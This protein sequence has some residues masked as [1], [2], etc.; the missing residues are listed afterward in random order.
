VFRPGTRRTAATFVAV[1]AAAAFTS[2][3][4]MAPASS[5]ANNGGGNPLDGN[6]V[7]LYT[8][9]PDPGA[10]AEIAKLAKGHDVKDALLVAK[11]VLTPQAV[12]V[13]KPAP[14]DARK[15]AQDAVQSADRRGEVPV[16]VAYNIPFRD[17]AGLSAGGASNT[18]A[19]ETWIDAL[20]HG[21][22]NNKAVVLL[23]PDSLGIIPYNTDINGTVES[24]KPD[25]STTGL[26]PAQA[27]AARYTQLN[28]AVDK[29]KGGRNTA[30]YLDGTHS[31]WLGS[32]DIA[33]RM[34]KAGVQR[35]DGFFL[36][37]SNFQFSANSVQYG[38]WISDCITFASVVNPGDFIDCPNQ[39]YNGGP[40]NGFA[41]G[42]ALSPY[43][44]WSDTATEF[45]LLTLGENQ[46]YANMLGSVA[47][48]THFIVDTSRN[49]VGPNN[50]SLYAQ[51]PFNQ[52]ANVISTLQ[53][54][55]W[56]NPPGRGNGLRPTTNTGNPLLDAYLWVKT[57][58]QSDGSCDISSG[59]RAWD[60][61]QYNPWGLTG[62]AQN[63]F[64]PLWGLVD[65]IAGGWFPQ[66]ALQ[67]AQLANPSL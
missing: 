60:F 52:P 32:G 23:E 33:Q 28:Y 17:C 14:N 29:L 8:P 67:L 47:P 66:Q 54:G 49:G 55:N 35:A 58:G 61:S 53:A 18:A 30:V 11:M 51:P 57:P 38:T 7:R 9:P 22:G 10:V 65:P 5:Q 20:A 26:T 36:N 15:A 6:H 41:T 21:I 43:G 34:V 19:Y 50:M 44:Q 42:T 1:A 63:H 24:C 45:D 4:A 64:D 31:A 2:L 13:T 37:V 3:T 46:R 59:A 39:Y 25:L 12:W 27:N 40:F 56:C 48:T 16:L 62:D